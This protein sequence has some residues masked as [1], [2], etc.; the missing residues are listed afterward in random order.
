MKFIIKLI[1]NMLG[2]WLAS[3][4]I[5]GI[6]LPPTE[7]PTEL[8]ITLAVI[9]IIFTAVNMI[10]R[11]VVKLVTFPVY[12][13]TLGLF[14]LVVNALMFMLTGWLSQHTSYGLEVTGFWPAL[15]GGVITALVAAVLGGALDSM[16]SRR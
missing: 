11:P 13:L 2:I 7:K 4:I 1:V 3:V 6:T 10:V 8:L 15:F 5:D 14:A 12:I 9:G 16:T